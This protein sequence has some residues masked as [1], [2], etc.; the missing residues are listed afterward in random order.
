MDCDTKKDVSYKGQKNGT[1]LRDSER[2]NNVKDNYKM[3][4]TNM[5]IY[6]KNGKKRNLR[7]GDS[8]GRITM[9]SQLFS[10]GS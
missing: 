2:Y 10:P 9:E 5:M 8:G 6:H 1:G 7:E 3:F 4:R